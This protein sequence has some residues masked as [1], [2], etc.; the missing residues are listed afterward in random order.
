MNK[1]LLELI[2]KRQSVRRYTDKAVEKEKLDRCLEAALLAPS[3]CNAQPWKF[4]VVD[5]PELVKKVARE[6]WGTLINFNKFVEQAPVLIVITIENSPIVP[7]MG[8]A[9]K[10]MDYPYIDIGIAAEHF[11]LQATAEGMGTC[12]LGWFNEKPIQKLLN[13]PKKRKIGLV[14][15]LGYEPE[16]YKVR[17]KVRKDIEKVVS[18]NRY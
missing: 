6:T 12:M 5:E 3:A 18:Y 7:K 2:R 15:S 8:K 9:I 10:N 4:I 14:I 17:E 16:G 13:I 1:S 11:C